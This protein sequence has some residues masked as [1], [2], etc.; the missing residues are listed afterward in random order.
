MAKKLY[1]GGLPYSYNETKLRELF[2][3]YTSISSVQLISDKFSGQSKGFGFIEFDDSEEADKAIASLNGTD[4]EGRSLTV[5]E[6]RPKT[7]G[8]GFGGGFGGGRNSGGG[9]GQRR[10]RNW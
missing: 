2:Q 9:S 5:N 1:V 3:A 4:C 6:A 10:E 7:A 8:G